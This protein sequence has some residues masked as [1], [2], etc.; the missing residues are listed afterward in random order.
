MFF[1]AG[2]VNVSDAVSSMSTGAR[3][4]PLLASPDNKN[5]NQSSFNAYKNNFNSQ[6]VEALALRV[7]L[8]FT[9]LWGHHMGGNSELLGNIVPMVDLILSALPSFGN[10]S[11]AGE[12]NI[13]KCF[14]RKMV[15]GRGSIP[16]DAVQLSILKLLRV[17][18]KMSS[19]VNVNE[20][21]D[22][23]LIGDE[24][25]DEACSAD[26]PYIRL[27]YDP[28]VTDISR[29]SLAGKAA[30]KSPVKPAK[31]S[32]HSNQPLVDFDS[33]P[34]SM[35]TASSSSSSSSSVDSSSGAN[36]FAVD[37]FSPQNKD[38]VISVSSSP[39]TQ[40]VFLNPLDIFDT[41]P[42][43][44]NT[45]SVMSPAS[46]FSDP[47][48]AVLKISPLDTLW[49]IS[50]A[51][52]QP[53]V[54]DQPAPPTT[55][56]FDENLS[57]AFSASSSS[58]VNNIKANSKEVD[59]FAP[60]VAGSG[61]PENAYYASQY[62]TPQPMHY[63]AP[64]PLQYPVQYPVVQYPMQYPPISQQPPHPNLNPPYY[65]NPMNP[66]PSYGALPNNS[67]QYP[68]YLPPSERIDKDNP[69]K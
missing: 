41:M 11:R 36:I 60:S 9:R 40:D 12:L 6:E 4:L 47:K 7:L 65:P 8:V 69:F 63:P 32:P 18:L 54:V 21:T 58:A 45:S 50:P 44:T 22:A 53:A 37:Q 62:T 33:W 28:W 24:L 26:L 68:T 49:A 27:I 17:L 67:Y 1:L 15:V 5:I 43:T 23:L 20:M 29:D 13:L 61:S 31:P 64:Y 39:I 46:S 52:A 51:P 25:V 2:L 56:A 35:G 48:P 59:D 66:N 16:R 34:L 42:P 14:I 19:S 38:G 55:D 30:T 10:A 3:N 57:A